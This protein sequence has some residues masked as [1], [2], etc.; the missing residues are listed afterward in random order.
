MRR[1]ILLVEDEPTL[2]MALCD[3]LEAEGYSVEL[4]STG[5]LAL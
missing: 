4:A 5:E 1:R 2:A 3:R